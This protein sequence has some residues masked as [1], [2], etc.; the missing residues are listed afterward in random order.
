MTEEPVRRRLRQKRSS[1]QAKLRRQA[2]IQKVIWISA[3]AAIS[4]AIIAIFT[5]YALLSGN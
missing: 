1:T 4:V 3:L 2:K 5:R